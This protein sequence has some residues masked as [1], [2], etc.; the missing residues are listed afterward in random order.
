MNRSISNAAG[1]LLVTGVPFVSY[2]SGWWPGTVSRV[3]KIDIDSA[4]PSNGLLHFGADVDGNTG[5]VVFCYQADTF[6]VGYLDAGDFA[7]ST[8]GYVLSASGWFKAKS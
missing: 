4:G 6:G 5:N 3:S 8:S 7:T 1:A 2:G